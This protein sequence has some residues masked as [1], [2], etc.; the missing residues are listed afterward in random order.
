MFL[1]S[2]N[3]SWG[4]ARSGTVPSLVLTTFR[5]GGPLP[6]P[7]NAFQCSGTLTALN[8]GATAAML[9]GRLKCVLNHWRCFAHTA[10]T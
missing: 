6:Q 9:P 1:R 4:P 3:V 10:I 5:T 8:R 2:Q 7:C